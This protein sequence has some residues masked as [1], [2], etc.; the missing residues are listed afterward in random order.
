MKMSKDAS[1]IT[2]SKTPPYPLSF[3]GENVRGGVYQTPP[4]EDSSE[5][6]GGGGRVRLKMGVTISQFL[7]VK[8][9][10]LLHNS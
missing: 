5:Y 7:T 2:F 3:S 1:G 4:C 9:R 8:N 10:Y 6:E